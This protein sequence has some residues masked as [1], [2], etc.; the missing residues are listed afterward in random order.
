MAEEMVFKTTIVD[1]GAAETYGPAMITAAQIRAARALLDWTQDELAAAAA[2]SLNSVKNT[3]RK[4]SDPRGNTLRAIQSA[5]ERH[6]V[7]FLEDGDTRDGGL[8]VR[9]KAKSGEE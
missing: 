1:Q 7:V 6:G 9:L 2:I 8:G 5:F 3:E 4:I